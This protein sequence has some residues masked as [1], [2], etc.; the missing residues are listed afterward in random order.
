MGY[1]TNTNIANGPQLGSQMSHYASLYTLHKKFGHEIVF[2]N[3]S[4]NAHRGVKLFN[5]F[6]LK[7]KIVPNFVKTKQPI[8]TEYLNPNTDYDIFGGFNVYTHWAK[9][10]SEIKDIFTFKPVFSDI[11]HKLLSDIKQDGIPIVSMHFRRTDYLSVSSLNLPITYYESAIKILDEKLKNYKILVLSDDIEWCKQ[12]IKGKNIFYSNGT[13]QYVDMCLM[14]MCDHNI[15]ANSSFSFWGAYL[16]ES[17]N[18]IV[19][20]PYEYVGINTGNLATELNGNWFLPEW[21]PIRIFL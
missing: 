11:A 3:D 2:I 13:N 18:K 14:T 9:Y 1:I 5:A 15:I 20:C 21:I 16:N 6:D 10:D 19:I 8:T 4:L 7:N 12:N 17:P